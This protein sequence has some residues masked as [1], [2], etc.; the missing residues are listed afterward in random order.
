MESS[1]H[2]QLK[3]HYQ[4]DQSETEAWVGDFRIDVVDHTRN[5]LI[6]IQS[7]SLASLRRKTR[8]LLTLGHCVWVVKPLAARKFLTLH[9]S[10][11]KTIVSQRWSPTKETLYHIFLELV[12]FV[13][14]FPHP[15]LTLEVLLTIQDEDRISKRPTRWKGKN[16]RVRDRTL[17][18]IEER[19]TLQTAK[20]LLDLLP[21]SLPA[22]FTTEDLA[23]HTSIP[24]WLAQKVAY[25]L[26][27]TEA[28]ALLGKRGNALLYGKPAQ[29]KRISR[30]KAA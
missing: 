21:V 4:D 29:A 18:S 19:Y 16:Y 27:K 24:R 25:C 3:A 5:R 11:G 20:D 9:D 7:A 15:Q 8:E 30:K 14:V 22:E 28:I 23:T 12:H 1:L 17:R 10:A 13:A 2:R 26:R 6:E